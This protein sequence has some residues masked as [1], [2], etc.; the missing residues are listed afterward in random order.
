MTYKTYIAA[1]MVAL[2]GSGC[3]TAIKGSHETFSVVTTPPGARVTT[4]VETKASI[5]ARLK[6]PTLTAEYM[7]CPATPCDFRMPRKA[8]FGV[9]LSRK[10][11]VDGFA[12]IESKAS[13]ISGQGSVAGN[14]A[15]SAT[16][17]ASLFTG[18]NSFAPLLT[19]T[20]GVAVGALTV[21][22][23]VPLVAI[24]YATGSLNGLTPNPLSVEMF[25]IEEAEK[26]PETDPEFFRTQLLNLE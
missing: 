17:A 20:P 15:P 26:L 11:Y 16:F 12:M 4:T 1:L 18:A 25:T 3:A 19:T 6:D 13:L 10:D 24:D 9:S 8:K 21:L 2:A 23:T 5:K 22:Y 7:G 14:S